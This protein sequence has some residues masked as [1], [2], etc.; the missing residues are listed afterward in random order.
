MGYAATLSW[1]L[2]LIV[3]AVTIFQARMQKSWVTYE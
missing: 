2:F 1:V 3:F